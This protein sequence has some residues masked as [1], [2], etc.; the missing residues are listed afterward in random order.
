LVDN[1]KLEN[2]GVV[3][4]RLE[5]INAPKS[6]PKPDEKDV[7]MTPLNQFPFMKKNQVT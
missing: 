3:L 2:E 1:H 7:F 6:E 4:D 5:K